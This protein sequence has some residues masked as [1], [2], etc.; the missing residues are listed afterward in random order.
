MI[1]TDMIEHK[2]G[3]G[4]GLFTGVF[5]SKQMQNTNQVNINLISLSSCSL[6]DHLTDADWICWSLIW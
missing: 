2:L 5:H 4:S 1:L 6:L 3:I